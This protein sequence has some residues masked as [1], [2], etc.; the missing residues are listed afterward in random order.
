MNKVA[1]ITGAAR[2]IG[3][4]IAIRLSKEMDVVINYQSSDEAAKQVADECLKAGHK[5]SLMKVNVADYEAC[6]GMMNQIIEEY[7]HLDVLVNN[8]GITADNLLLR[9]SEEDYDKVMEINAKGCFNCMKHA[10]RTMMKQRSGVIINM[11]SVI[12]LVGN[13]GQ[14]NYAASK[15]A[16]I[17]MSK[18]GAK[19]LASRNIR[20]NAVAPGYI[21]TAMTSKLNETIKTDILSKIP[22]SRMGTAEDVADVVEFLA[23]DK[24]QYITGQVINVDGGMVI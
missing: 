15:A 8:A 24:S 14:L 4:A 6:Q 17:A 11:A 5:V 9:M 7:G 21:D 16:I 12:G 1:L 3:A 10:T 2:G 13:I 22:L 23:S 19:E 20:V 18:S